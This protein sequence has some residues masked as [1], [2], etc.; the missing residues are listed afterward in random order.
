M[1]LRWVVVGVCLLVVSGCGEG[2]LSSQDFE[3]AFEQATC[4]RATRCGLVTDVDTCAQGSTW[5]GSQALA[6]LAAG[7]AGYDGDSASACVEAVRAA[8]CVETHDAIPP[9][10][11][12]FTGALHDDDTC[13]FDFECASRR[14]VKVECDRQCCTG[15]CMEPSGE[16]AACQAASDCQG[17]LICEGLEGEPAT[18]HRRVALGAHCETSFECDPS[19]YC[20]LVFSPTDVP[21]GG[22]CLARSPQGGVCDA[23]FPDESCLGVD[24]FCNPPA[25]L[26]TSRGAP[27]ESCEFLHAGLSI[28]GDTCRFEG[29]CDP[30]TRRCAAW[31]AAGAPCLQG[32]CAAGYQCDTNDLCVLGEVPAVCP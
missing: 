16:G 17:G 22:T 1:T 9:C 23:G 30:D 10:D 14:C 5:D 3:A 32:R 31:P 29:T 25:E 21:L 15:V 7:R 4:E 11:D 24:E 26:C 18:C 13:W 28:R 12:V 8:S 19:A 27:G 20:A 6:S 2:G